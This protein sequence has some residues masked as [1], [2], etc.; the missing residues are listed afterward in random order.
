MSKKEIDNSQK[1]VIQPEDFNK[2][3]TGSV[4]QN[5]CSEKF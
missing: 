3:Q 5:G 1:T 2:L 4:I